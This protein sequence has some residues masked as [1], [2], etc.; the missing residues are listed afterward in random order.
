MEEWMNT[1]ISRLEAEYKTVPPPWVLFNE[2]P[3]SMRWRM[4]DGEAHIELWWEW[5]KKQ[6]LSEN[7][8]IDYFRL[9]KPPHCW[10]K[11]LIE[12]IWE[13]QGFENEKDLDPFFNQT[14]ELGFG[15]RKDYERDLEDPKWHKHSF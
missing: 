5:W 15:S 9:Y 1:E 10:L 3:Y 11:F 2:H 12:A 13:I 6:N 8:R 4:G 14:K 7:Q